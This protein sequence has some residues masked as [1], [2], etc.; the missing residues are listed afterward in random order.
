[1]ADIMMLGLRGIS[2]VQGGVETHVRNL[3]ENFPADLH[4]DVIERS[5]V[6]GERVKTSGH[7][8]T[9]SVW[10]PNSKGTEAIVH[11]F[12]GVL[13]AA[14]H[15]PRVLHIHAIGPALLTPIARALGLKVVVTHHGRDY[16]REKWGPLA[17]SMLRAGEWMTARFANERIAVSRT[18]ADELSAQYRR[19]FHYIPNGYAVPLPLID[20]GFLL[21]HGLVRGKFV[22]NVGRIVPEKRQLDC[23]R[24][25]RRIEDLDARLVLAGGIDHGSSYAQALAAAAAE[26]P[27]V[28]MLGSISMQELSQLYANTALFVLPSSHE[29]MPIALLEAM[30]Y[31]CKII[32]SD[33]APLASLNLG[34]DSY[35]QLGSIEGLAKAMDAALKQGIATQD[36]SARLKDFTWSNVANQTLAVYDRIR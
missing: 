32:V 19:P 11:T 22:L 14:R 4:C 7:I 26:D 6:A 13:H 10:S 31:E 34:A 17:R 30:S 18:L 24:A 23:V 8:R 29:G 3:V 16:L 35:F 20:D 27:R 2:G 5:Y 9:V 33:I 15:R 12:M 36:W 25:F 1:M 28:L 21:Q